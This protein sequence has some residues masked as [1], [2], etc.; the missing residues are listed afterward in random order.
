MHHGGTCVGFGA[1]PGHLQ[2]LSLAL[3]LGSIKFSWQSLGDYMEKCGS[4]L[5]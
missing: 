2:C 4:N 1:M 5:G 3:H